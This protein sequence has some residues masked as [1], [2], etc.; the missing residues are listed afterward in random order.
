M[1]EDY[2]KALQDLAHS[3]KALPGIGQRT[4]ER[5]AIALLDWD[6][7]HLHEFSDQLRTLKSR[8][9]QC[10]ICGNLAEGAECRICRNP[11]RDHKV[12]CVVESARQIPVV[13]KCRRFAGLYH[14]LGGRVSPL[15]GVEFRDLNVETLFKR[16]SE[17]S[18]TE[19]IIATS[20]DVEGEATATYLG[21]ETRRQFDIKISRI[22]LG[23]PVGSDL[24]FADSATMAMAIDNRQPMV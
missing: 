6:E 2:P 1:M 11:A 18:I 14:V 3:L 24:T 22:S 13:E 12:I 8:V 23:V 10:T 20:P 4:A 21:D 9:T 17:H 15:D 5:L 7:T 19:L 16:I